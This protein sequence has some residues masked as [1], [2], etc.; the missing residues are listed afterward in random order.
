LAAE[1]KKYLYKILN[2]VTDLNPYFEHPYVIGQLLLPDYN[3]RYEKL[4]DKEQ[5]KHIN[6]AEEI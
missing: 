3:Y 5:E 1:Y 6:E 4:D 2:L